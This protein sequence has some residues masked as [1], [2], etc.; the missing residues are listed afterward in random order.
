MRFIPTHVGQMTATWCN[1]KTRRRFIP[2]HV[3]QMNVA[4]SFRWCSIRFIPTHVGQIPE[5]HARS[6][7]AD[8]SSPRTWGKCHFLYSQIPDIPRFIPTHVGQMQDLVAAGLNPIR[9]IPTHVGQITLYNANRSDFKV[10]PHARGANV[11]YW[12]S[13]GSED[14][15]SPRTW[16]K[17]LLLMVPMF[18][19]RFIPTHVGQML[20]R[21]AIVFLLFGSSPRTW[22]KFYAPAN[23]LAVSAVHP[24]ARG[25][26][27]KKNIEITRFLCTGFPLSLPHVSLA[28]QSSLS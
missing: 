25:A 13:L 4:T 26:N 1:W 7:A 19:H 23:A 9:F 17:L 22:G 28:R 11:E 20:R 6:P 16:G 27:T 18:R 24:H 21:K 15:S 8:G 5:P 12:Q 14:G 3:G 2:T 10:H